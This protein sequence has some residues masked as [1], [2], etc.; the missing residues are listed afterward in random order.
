MCVC[1]LGEG[2]VVE[3]VWVWVWVG[4][5][6]NVLLFPLFFFTISAHH[7]CFLTLLYVCMYVYVCMNVS[8]MDAL[9]Y[10]AAP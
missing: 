10:A 8:R 4:V 5:S 3:G 9:K 2:G 7:F 1:L 6:V